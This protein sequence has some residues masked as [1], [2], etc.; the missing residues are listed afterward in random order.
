MVCNIQSVLCEC[1][2]LKTLDRLLLNLEVNWQR[3]SVLQLN[4]GV[5]KESTTIAEHS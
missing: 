4:S 3:T 5:Y 2:E 1:V